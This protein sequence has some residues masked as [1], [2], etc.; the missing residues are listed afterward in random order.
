MAFAFALSKDADPASDRPIYLPVDIIGRN[1]RFF[2]LLYQQR[3]LFFFFRQY[4]YFFID[5]QFNKRSFLK[6]IQLI[7]DSYRR[8]HF[9]DVREQKW[10][11]LQI[12][13][14]IS[15]IYIQLKKICVS[16]LKKNPYRSVY[17]S[18]RG[19]KSTGVR[20]RGGEMC[21]EELFG[22]L[23]VFSAL[24]AHIHVFMSIFIL[25]H[26]LRLLIM[27][28]HLFIHYICFM[29]IIYI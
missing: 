11:R 3:T 13:K 29:D 9:Y 12:S 10:Y 24:S 19:L 2:L 1:Q 26:I 16:V 7:I 18:R 28:I 15:K 21:S 23:K 17:T 6:L 14:N 4:L 22:R 20:G 25:R 8:C 27:V 5:R